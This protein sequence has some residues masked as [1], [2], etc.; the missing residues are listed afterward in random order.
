MENKLCE[1]IIGMLVSLSNKMS[2]E[3]LYSELCVSIEA[4][5]AY[6]VGQRVP[7]D[8]VKYRI[9]MKNIEMTK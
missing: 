1:M 3:T 6:L 2:L 8:E 7:R 9:I 4:L 5:N